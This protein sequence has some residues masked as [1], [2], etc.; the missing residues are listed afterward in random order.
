LLELLQH[1]YQQPA[2]A[3]RNPN[4]MVELQDENG[5]VC[6]VPRHIAEQA[7]GAFVGS[8]SRRM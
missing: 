3:A 4:D 1:H 6:V 5:Q 7:G 2:Q 8:F